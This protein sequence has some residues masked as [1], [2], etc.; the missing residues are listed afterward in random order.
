MG[1]QE[2]EIS[3]WIE[4]ANSWDGSAHPN[5]PERD[6]QAHRDMNK[7]V[8]KQAISKAEIAW[9]GTHENVGV[10]TKTLSGDDVKAAIG[11][12]VVESFVAY[13]TSV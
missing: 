7:A 12:E 8:A 2:L 10:V 5:E 9:N 11:G 3:Q 6:E 13:A 4:K 1:T